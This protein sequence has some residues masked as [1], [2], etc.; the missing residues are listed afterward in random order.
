M[1]NAMLSALSAARSE[2]IVQ[3]ADTPEL[4]RAAL[5]V[6]H[7]VY[8]LER[9]YEPGEGG[10]ET[11]GFDVRSLHV[12]LRKRIDGKAI[13]TVRLILADAGQG[14]AGFP[15]REVCADVM[16]AGLPADRAA[17]VSRFSVGRDRDGLS[18]GAAGMARL[19]LVQGLVELSRQA[20]ITVWCAMMEPKLLRLLR[21]SAIHFAALGPAVEYHGMRQP[22]AC[23][24]DQMLARMGREQP[25][26]WS[27]VADE[28]AEEFLLAA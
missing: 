3:I 23:D 13:G 22:A 6:R 20:G 7:Q 21:A 11:D 24:V 12:V 2:L 17:E 27:Y 5:Q 26:L 9:G 4:I 18:A 15:M 10:I 25:A 28:Y 14:A 8:C 1:V 16:F 19:A